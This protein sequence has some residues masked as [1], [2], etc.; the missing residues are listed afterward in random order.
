MLCIVRQQN[1]LSK[2]KFLRFNLAT[3]WFTVCLREANLFCASNIWVIHWKSVGP[4]VASTVLFVTSVQC[5]LPRS[6]AEGRGKY[7]SVHRSQ[8]AGSMRWVFSGNTPLAT[9]AVCLGSCQKTFTIRSGIFTRFARTAF[10]S[11]RP[12]ANFSKG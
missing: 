4:R 9:P 11:W 6:V 3:I 10:S 1:N 12:G 2:I 5:R 7:T 8:T